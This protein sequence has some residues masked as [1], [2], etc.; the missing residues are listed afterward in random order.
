MDFRSSFLAWLGLFKSDDAAH[1]LTVV[2]GCVS[3]LPVWGLARSI[4]GERVDFAA[5]LLIAVSLVRLAFSGRSWLHP[6]L[7][8]RRSGLPVLPPSTGNRSRPRLADVLRVW[9][10]RDVRPL[11]LRNTVAQ[12]CLVLLLEP[13]SRPRIRGAATALS[14][15]VVVTLPLPW[16]ASA[17]F[18]SKT[19]TAFAI[20]IPTRRDPVLLF[21]LLAGCSIGPSIAE[22]HKTT[23]AEAATSLGGWLIALGF[24]VV[25]VAIHGARVLGGTW[26][27]RLGLL[28]IVPVLVWSFW[29]AS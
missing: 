9:D 12:Q 10:H 14:L 27:R 17:D 26:T 3:V 19:R 4:G 18:A 8:G 11:P 20:P 22:L 21:A 6:V 25:V 2:L 24:G 15:L 29:P 28:V 1:G 23:A 7:S 13:L 16:L 5:A